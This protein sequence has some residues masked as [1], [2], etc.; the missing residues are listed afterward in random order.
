MYAANIVPAP[1]YFL[2]VAVLSRKMKNYE[3]EIEYCEK[4]IDAVED[5]YKNSNSSKLA[6]VRKGPVYKKIVARLPKAK[7]LLRKEHSLS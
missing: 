1:F 2:R 3:Q 4:Y 5:F 6:D 7:E